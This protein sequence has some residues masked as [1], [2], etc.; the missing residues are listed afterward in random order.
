VGH[1]Y[2]FEF[3]L[4]MIIQF[5]LPAFGVSIKDCGKRKASKHEKSM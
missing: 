3:D 4:A 2:S 1:G 5:F